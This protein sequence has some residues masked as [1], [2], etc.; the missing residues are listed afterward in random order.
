VGPTDQALLAT[1]VTAWLVREGGKV[2]L[3][4]EEWQ[5][6]IDHD[7][8]IYVHAL[9]PEAPVMIALLVKEAAEA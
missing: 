7:A 6:A 8:T 2:I 1:A 4:P 5:A 9:S 3:T